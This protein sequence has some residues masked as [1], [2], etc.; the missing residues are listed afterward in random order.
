MATRQGKRYGVEKG[1]QRNKEEEIGQ[2]KPNR[3]P[4]QS[5]A[6]RL[7]PSL[8]ENVGSSQMRDIGRI[9]RGMNPTGQSA[10][11]RSAQQQAGGRALMR[12][13]SRA[14]LIGAAASAGY[15]IG[16]AIAADERGANLENVANRGKFESLM[17]RPVAAPKKAAKSVSM[18]DM[19]KPVAAPKA[20][21]KTSAP[22]MEERGVREG[23][24]ENISDDVRARAMASVAELEDVNKKNKWKGTM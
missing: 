18:S 6:N 7:A 9:G 3:S 11:T 14:G 2:N 23:P 1:I 15:E 12:T 22:K 4:G 13:A 5:N 16:S 8:R 20:K 19:P 10:L 17:D 24:N 21:A